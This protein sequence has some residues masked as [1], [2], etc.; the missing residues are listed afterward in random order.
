MMSYCQQGPLFE[1]HTAK[2]AHLIMN[3]CTVGGVI[4]PSYGA[5]V[6]AAVLLVAVAP[7]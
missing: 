7:S 3:Y 5:V 6:D 1:V 2:A 4:T